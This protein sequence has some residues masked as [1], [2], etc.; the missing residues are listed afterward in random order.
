MRTCTHIAIYK[1][2]VKIADAQI[3]GKRGLTIKE[4]VNGHGNDRNWTHIIR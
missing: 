2:N 4:A 1:Q 3:S